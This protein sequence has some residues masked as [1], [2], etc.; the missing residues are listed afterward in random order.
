MACLVTFDLGYVAKRPLV[1]GLE[2]DL[3]TP[4]D[5]VVP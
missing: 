4:E 1:P 5:D 2:T 3:Y